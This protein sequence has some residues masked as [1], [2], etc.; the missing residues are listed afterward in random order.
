MHPLHLPTIPFG[1]ADSPLH[2][3][4]YD[5]ALMETHESNVALYGLVRARV[6]VTEVWLTGE[7]AVSR[8]E[9]IYN[10]TLRILQERANKYGS[11]VDTVPVDSLATPEQ[12]VQ[13]QLKNQ[14][15]QLVKPLCFSME[16]HIRHMA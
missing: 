3:L 5:S 2:Q 15:A 6:A 10:Q 1:N 4:T 14:L 9:F 12:R 13:L 8:L 16:E 11:A 7:A